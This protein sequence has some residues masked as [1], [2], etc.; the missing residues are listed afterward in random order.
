MSF[1]VVDHTLNFLLKCVKVKINSPS[2]YWTRG[3]SSGQRNPLRLISS[4]FSLYG[5][6][7]FYPW[8][9]E[10][11]SK[12]SLLISHLMNLLLNNPSV[13]FPSLLQNNKK[14]LTD[15]RFDDKEFERSRICLVSQLEAF[16]S[17]QRQPNSEEEMIYYVY[18]PGWF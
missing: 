7:F 6:Y 2:W 9:P 16:N 14:R 1:R 17:K 18:N 3:R 13:L 4:S 15:P 10:S 11:Q 5:S 8:D 12:K